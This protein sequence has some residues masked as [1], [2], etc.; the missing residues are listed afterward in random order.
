M[1]K[2][3]CIKSIN[4]SLS[5]LEKLRNR[6]ILITGG[7][8]F[9]GTWLTEMLNLLNHEYGL[10]IKIYLLARNEPNNFAFKGVENVYFIKSDIR[11][12]KEIPN[13]IN[14][15]IHA[16]GSPDSREHVSNPIRTLDTFYKGTQNILDQA[17]RLPNL[18]KI[19]HLSSN[20]VYGSNYTTQSISEIDCVSAFFQNNDIYTEAKRVS[21]SICKAFISELHL[22]IVI[23]RPF[24]FFGPFQSLEKPWAI[25]NFIRDAILGGPI[26]I[27]GNENTTKSYLYGSDLA[28]FL[29]NL[30]ISGESGEVYNI[31]DSTPIKLLDLAHK[32]KDSIDLSIEIRVKSSK[33][34]Y[35][36]TLFDVPNCSKIEKITCFKPVFSFDEALRRTIA[37]NIMKVQKN[38]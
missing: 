9:V 15:I 21:E 37:W 8:G 6:H 22:P 24:A 13:K 14:Y 12:L 19:L 10:G 38:G 2:E 30:L 26:R 16:A 28:A 31:G 27:L 11:N 33:D 20:K 25:N 34:E 3:D 29:L 32:I 1:I 36:S 5:T 4:N 35:T 17:S 18:I 23:I 7:T